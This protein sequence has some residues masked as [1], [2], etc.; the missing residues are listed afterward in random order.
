MA[1]RG[2]DHR[3]SHNTEF[4]AASAHTPARDRTPRSA[5]TE[6]RLDEKRSFDAEAFDMGMLDTCMG[7]PPSW[8]RRRRR[9]RRCWRRIS[10]GSC[11]K[12]LGSYR[13]RA[14]PVDGR[15]SR[16]EAGTG[17]WLVSTGIRS[18]DCSHA[19]SGAL[20]VLNAVPRLKPWAKFQGPL[21]GPSGGGACQIPDDA[22]RVMVWS[23]RASRSLS[24]LSSKTM[25]STPRKPS[26]VRIQNIKKRVSMADRAGSQR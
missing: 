7:W 20:S 2:A 13:G 4:E 10:R 1:D 14:G 23:E 24:W 6:I 21:P 16:S 17:T 8:R 15:C 18:T 22:L 25:S 26:G 11:R 19:P 9:K 3:G 5:A 12:V